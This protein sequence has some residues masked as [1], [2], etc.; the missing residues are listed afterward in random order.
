[1]A[2]PKILVAMD[3]DHTLVD[4]NVDVLIK[5]LAGSTGLPEYVEEVK[6]RS[7]W[8]AYMS[9]IFKYLFKNNV[10]QEDYMKCLSEA[11]LVEGMKELLQLMHKS[12][13]CEIIILSDAN[14]FFINYLLQYH[15][16][17]STITKVFTNPS[18]F[19]KDGCLQIQKFMEKNDCSRCPDNLCKGL[20]LQNYVSQKLSEG[21][22]FYRILY[23]GDG[24]NDICPALKLTNNDY[25]FARVGYRLLRALE[26][27]PAKDVKPAVVPWENGHDIKN[28]L[29]T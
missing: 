15:Q 9:E 2:S 25:V 23:I 18:E 24:Y 12:G 26:K 10:T 5:A 19:D 3:F 8:T 11:P 4:F 16:L 29:L 22:K 13:E 14:S 7:G 17:S 27:M 21:M 6:D 20:V 1:M 28:A